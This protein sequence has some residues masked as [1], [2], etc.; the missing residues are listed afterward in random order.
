MA[1]SKSTMMAIEGL[2]YS[3]VV[4]AIARN[5]V[6]VGIRVSGTEGAWY[7]AT[8]DVPQGLCFPDTPRQMPTLIWATV[9]YTETAGIG[10]FAMG[11]APAIVQ[12]VGNI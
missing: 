3:T 8:A 10:A 2:D 6:E 12:F 7:C 4:T 11:A 1:A 9:Q 5:G